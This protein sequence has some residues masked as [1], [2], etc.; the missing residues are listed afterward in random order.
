MST[1]E[2]KYTHVNRNND[3]IKTLKT[4][5]VNKS[6]L[7]E[8]GMHKTKQMEILNAHD[9]SLSTNENPDSLSIYFDFYY[10]FEQTS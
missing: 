9:S 6:R 5:F 2:T 3:A 8:M 7:I 1:D 4:K 10:L